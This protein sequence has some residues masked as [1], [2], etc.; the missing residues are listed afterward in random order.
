MTLHIYWL[1]GYTK[2]KSSEV[3]NAINNLAE[4]I[5]IHHTQMLAVGALPQPR[6]NNNISADFIVAVSDS[7]YDEFLSSLTEVLLRF[8]VKPIPVNQH[9]PAQSSL[10][11]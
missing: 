5:E 1:D 6:P 7:T 8:Q 3:K 9:P 2:E 4:L 10:E 11:R